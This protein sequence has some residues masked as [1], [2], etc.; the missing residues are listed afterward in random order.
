MDEAKTYSHASTLT[1][2]IANTKLDGEQI[3]IDV[4]KV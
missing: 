4:S 1:F 3:K 2:A